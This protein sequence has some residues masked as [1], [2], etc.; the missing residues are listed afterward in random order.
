MTKQTKC[1]TVLFFKKTLFVFV[2]A[3]WGQKC[4]RTDNVAI[5]CQSWKNSE[6]LVFL[7]SLQCTDECG[8]NGN[9]KN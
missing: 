7:K 1:K 6:R 4:K 8:G 3:T 2:K 5:Y 9:D